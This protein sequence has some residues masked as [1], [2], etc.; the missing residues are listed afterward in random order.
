MSI[1]IDSQA[2][3]RFFGLVRRFVA[4]AKTWQVVVLHNVT[5]QEQHDPTLIS[6]RVYGNRNE[7]LTVMA[8]AGTNS[9]DQPIPQKQLIL[10][11]QAQLFKLKR[12]AGFE[13]DPQY[14][15]SGKPTWVE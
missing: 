1:D 9:F 13:S 12:D 15:D 14:R 5:P 10:P 11:T 7:Y 4:R 2:A 8:A 6:Q 3:R